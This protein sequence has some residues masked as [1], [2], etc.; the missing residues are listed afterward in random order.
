MRTDAAHDY[1]NVIVGNKASLITNIPSRLT[2]DSTSII[3]HIITN[4]S[5][6]QLNSFIFDVTVSNH[7]SIC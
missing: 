4:D 7:Y 3:D 2:S 6:L 1:I 5:N